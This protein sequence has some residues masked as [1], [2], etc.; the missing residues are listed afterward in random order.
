MDGRVNNRDVGPVYAVLSKEG[1]PL[2]SS[3]VI[4]TVAWGGGVV[5]TAAWAAKDIPIQIN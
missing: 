2:S 4:N 1:Q 3:Q 5:G